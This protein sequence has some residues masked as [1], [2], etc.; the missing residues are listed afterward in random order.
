MTSPET[1]AS[2]LNQPQF[3][4]VAKNRFFSKNEFLRSFGEWLSTGVASGQGKIRSYKQQQAKSS[5]GNYYHRFIRMLMNYFEIMT[6]RQI[7][8]ENQV[9]TSTTRL[10]AV[11]SAVNRYPVI[12][13]IDY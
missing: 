11:R 1:K 3:H 10:F 6:P 5:N 4:A 7:T 2:S 12:D 8:S 9:F 13:Y